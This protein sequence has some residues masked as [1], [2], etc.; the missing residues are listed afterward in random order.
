MKK[1]SMRRVAKGLSWLQRVASEG[2][3]IIE[4]TDSSTAV[5][6]PIVVSRT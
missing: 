5:K 1:V 6:P 3:S 2:S 4:K